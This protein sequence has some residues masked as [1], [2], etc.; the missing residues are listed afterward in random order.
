MIEFIS[1]TVHPC[2]AVKRR[3]LLEA[4]DEGGMD[5]LVSIIQ[6]SLGDRSPIKL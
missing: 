3:R 5:R 4:A 2:G 6:P 1:V